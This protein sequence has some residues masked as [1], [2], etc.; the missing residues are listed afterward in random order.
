MR[1]CRE[2]LIL[3]GL[4]FADL[5]ST[6][7]LVCHRGASEANVVMGYYLQHGLLVFVAA[8]CVLFIPS[9]FIAEWY[10]RRNAPLITHTLRIVIALYVGLYSVGV[11]AANYLPPAEAEQAWSWPHPRPHL[12]DSSVRASGLLPGSTR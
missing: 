10:R 5:V 8:K 6:V 9:L 12:R 7:F 2:S 11:F 3:A 1:L 4:C